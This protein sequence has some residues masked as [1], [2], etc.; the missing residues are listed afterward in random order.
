MRRG[1]KSL[2]RRREII[3][4]GFVDGLVD[5]EGDFGGQGREPIGSWKTHGWN[6]QC[7]CHQPSR[8]ST[9]FP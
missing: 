6:V 2:P 8:S 3:S 9:L 5:L 7:L 4:G 1:H